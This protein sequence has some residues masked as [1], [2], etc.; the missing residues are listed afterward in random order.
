[1][2]ELHTMKAAV[3][4]AFHGPNRS[5]PLVPATAVGLSSL[6]NRLRKVGGPLVRGPSSETRE[7]G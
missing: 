1:M 5:S 6:L 7:D 3:Y 2:P 4:R